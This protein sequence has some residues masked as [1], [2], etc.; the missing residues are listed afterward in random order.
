MT[1]AFETEANTEA[2]NTEAAN[3]YLAKQAE[4]EV[5]E[6]EDTRLKLLEKVSCTIKKAFKGTPVEIYLV[7]SII[8]P[9]QFT[10]YSDVDIV[11]KNSTSDSFD[12]WKSIENEVGRELEV[13]LFEKCHFQESIVTHGMRI[14]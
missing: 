8:R 4:K 9:Y 1:S 14:V 2:V 6:M 10:E 5:S 11:V 13:I 3:K 12:L 7:G